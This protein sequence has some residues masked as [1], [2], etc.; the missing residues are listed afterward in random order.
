[1]TDAK[2]AL[3]LPRGIE[4]VAHGGKDD[5][6]RLAPLHQV[7]QQRHAGGEEAGEQPGM[8]KGHAGELASTT[9]SA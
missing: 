1:M 5:G 4:Q 7:Q 2:T 3:V 9:R 8:K 6:G